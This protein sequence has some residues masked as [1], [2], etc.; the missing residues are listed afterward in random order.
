M[1]PQDCQR[2]RTQ[3]VP[4]SANQNP[5]DPRFH[6]N[7]V[8][9]AVA[10]QRSFQQSMGVTLNGGHGQHSSP[11]SNARAGPSTPSR[12][13]RLQNGI[14][15]SNNS[16]N[17]TMTSQLGSP[18]EFQPTLSRPSPQQQRP[19]VQGMRPANMG[20]KVPNHSQLQPQLHQGQ[21]LRPGL[22]IGVA[23]NVYGTAQAP[24]DTTMY[25]QMYGNSDITDPFLTPMQ[26]TGTMSSFGNEG[27]MATTAPANEV[28]FRSEYWGCPAM[29]NNPMSQ[30]G[31]N[32]T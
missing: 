23:Q 8:M 17:N 1:G 30:G 28:G 7:V 13:P 16:Q 32:G 2:D 20:S 18:F 31:N 10:P 4:S 11:N 12:I 19:Y 26:A 27:L 25:G 15:G 9:S 22:D 24:L 14:S 3:C 21:T 29:P 6:S 5:R